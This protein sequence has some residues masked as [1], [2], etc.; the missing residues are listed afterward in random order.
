MNNFKQHIF[1]SFSCDLWTYLK[2]VTKPILIYGMGNGADKIIR[3]LES[4]GV[5]YSDVFASD[6]FVRGHSYRGK[7]VLSFSQ[8]VEKYKDFIILL[9]FGTHLDDVMKRIYEL[10]ST[11]ELYAPD[12]PVCEGDLFNEEFFE[13]HETELSEA[14]EL[15]FDSRSKEVFDDVIRFKLSGKIEFL[16]SSQDTDSDI[17][18]ILSYENHTSFLDLGAY[19]GDTVKK[20]SKLCPNLRKIYAFEPDFRNFKKLCAYCETL[21]DIDVQAYNYAS[22]NEDTTLEFSASGNRNSTGSGTASHQ[23][24]FITV[25]ARKPDSVVESVDFIKYDVEGAEYRAILGSKELLTSCAPDLL[26]SLYHKSEDLFTLPKLLNSINPSYKLFLRR[27][28][29]IPA[30]ELNLYAKI[31]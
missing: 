3:V 7:T 11:Y 27:L 25:E 29:C 4:Y 10:D 22:W 28:P 14:R 17:D 16:K 23:T 9:S 24:K 31:N 5:T 6:G 8:A 20:Y 18:S 13:K 1:S 12:V 19:N 21:T 15:L 2:G 26:V 30:W